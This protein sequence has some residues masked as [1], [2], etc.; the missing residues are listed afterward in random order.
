MGLNARDGEVRE[1]EFFA[2]GGQNKKR[3]FFLDKEGSLRYKANLKI[4]NKKLRTEK[5]SGKKM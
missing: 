3:N 1:N 2:F 5:I 4:C